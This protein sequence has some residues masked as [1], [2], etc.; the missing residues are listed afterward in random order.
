MAK[1][2]DNTEALDLAVETEIDVAPEERVEWET[3][4]FPNGTKFKMKKRVEQEERYELP[5]GVQVVKKNAL[6]ADMIK[7]IRQAGS[8]VDR[9]TLLLI[10]HLID[11]I[12][13]DGN[14]TKMQLEDIQDLPLEDF[15]ALQELVNVEKKARPIPALT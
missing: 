9:I 3:R 11:F 15:L 6:G 2:T 1:R 4:E 14:R 10:Y 5:C 7:I 13:E 12:D 8:K